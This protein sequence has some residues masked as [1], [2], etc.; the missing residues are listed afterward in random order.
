MKAHQLWFTEPGTVTIQEVE[1]PALKSD[2]VFVRTW[3][4][5]ISAG[6]E[7]LVYRHQ[8]PATMTLD[9]SLPSLENQNSYPLQYGY[10]AVG[11]VEGVG[12]GVDPDWQNKLVFAFQPHA[13][14]FITTPD[15]VFPLPEEMDP[16]AA[17]FLAN[18][19]TAV[20]LVQDAAPG[21]GERV[22]VIGQ[23][24][25]GL[26]VSSLL[27]AFPLA[28]LYA[29]ET[30]EERRHLAQRLA[31][32][33]AL[34]PG[35]EIELNTLKQA[36][37]M[38]QPKDGADLVFELSG[39]PDALNLAIEFT[40]FSGRIVVGSW[41]GDK[42]TPLNLGGRFHR[43][44]MQLI[45]SQV[46]TLAPHLTGRWE[47]S[48]RLQVAWDMICRT[49]PEQFITHRIPFSSAADAY[50]LLDQTPEDVLQAVFVYDS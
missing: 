32:D 2:E 50:Q 26:L 38:H 21:I 11:R 6:T 43:N 20:N 14:H 49:H 16:L 29:L 47:K 42:N 19:E 45:S 31:V 7:M 39:N 37:H 8:I 1:L 40:S 22:I 34:H 4:S 36:L 24:V 25:L 13:S 10:A 28:G 41:Y 12:S 46:S 44:R 27:N 5:A 30:L 3:Y 33:K 9:D 23:G 18:M 35:F 15:Q 48:R 17:V